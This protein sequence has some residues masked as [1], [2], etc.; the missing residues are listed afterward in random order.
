M[1]CE[2][3]KIIGWIDPASLEKPKKAKCETSVAFNDLYNEATKAIKENKI[4]ENQFRGS[5][6]ESVT[7]DL[8][9]VKN[10]KKE[11]DLSRN[12]E[13]KELYKYAEIM[14]AILVNFINSSQW[15]GEGAHAANT[16]DFDDI[17]NKIDI[18]VELM[19]EKGFSKNLGLA[20]DASFS[21]DLLSKFE[22]IKIKIERGELSEIKYYKS[23]NFKGRLSGIPRVVT[24]I[25]LKTVKELAGMWF[26]GDEEGIKNHP[27]QYQILEEMILQLETF[28]QY[29]GECGNLELEKV[30]HDS[31]LTIK[32]ILTERQE[33]RSDTGK[34]DYSSENL[35]NCLKIFSKQQ[36]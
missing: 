35:S 10:L 12:E 9:T 28:E 6:G 2:K 25:N 4:S 3:C 24:S 30:Y 17:K 27:A 13:E 14:Q 29:A 8:T 33:N 15:L 31:C 22:E 16:S 5:Y 23:G 32:E 34:R 20:I 21:K 26:R 1:G 36:E 11:F 18:I 19:N 7:R